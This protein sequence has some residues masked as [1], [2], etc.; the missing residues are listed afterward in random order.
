MLKRLVGALVLLGLM[1]YLLP[2]APVSAVRGTPGSSEFGFGA[3]IDVNGQLVEDSLQLANNLKLDWVALDLN[4]KQIQAEKNGPVD[5]S[6]YDP[7]FENLA[8]YQIAALVSLT[9][10][11]DWSLGPAGPDPAAAANILSLLVDKY[12]AAVA[13]I[14]LFPSANTVEGWGA[15]PD[16]ISY[17]NLVKTVHKHLSSTKSGVILVAGGL[18]PV[19]DNTQPGKAGDLEFLRGLY[20][21]GAKDVFQVLSIRLQ[22]LSGSPA[23]V[24]ENRQQQVLRHYEEIRDVMVKYGHQKGLMWITGLSIPAS[25][26]EKEGLAGSTT[27][28]QTAWLAQAYQQLR[29][30]LYIGV[31]FLSQMNPPANG[32][33][34]ASGPSLILPS[35]DLAPIYRVLRDQIAQNTSAGASS[36]PGRP[37]SEILSKG[38]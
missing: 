10:P 23:A 16:P 36:R 11:P 24:S 27:Q 6:L 26:E 32:S 20:L 14:E 8:H 3:R 9:Q 34:H 25:M 5:W 30:Q 4:W 7:I 18:E 17:L 33:D 1:I 21:A 28:A 15:D 31:A 2:N 38:H 19:A 13:A 37:K 22:D 35:G 29:S 12:G